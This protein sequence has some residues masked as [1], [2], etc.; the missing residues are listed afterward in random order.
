MFAPARRRAAAP[1]TVPRLVSRANTRCAR[2]HGDVRRPLT[3][4]AARS[5][6][7]PRPATQPCSELTRRYVDVR[8]PRLWRYAAA[9]DVTVAQRASLR[10][11]V[12]AHPVLLIRAITEHPIELPLRDGHEIRMGDPR[13][14]EP[15]A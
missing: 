7:R 1:T 4:S 2:F 11:H 5:R 15:V 3:H 6:A 13:A 12:F 14:V 10:P 8:V 9:I